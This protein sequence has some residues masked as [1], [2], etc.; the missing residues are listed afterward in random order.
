MK[1]SPTMAAEKKHTT[2]PQ[3]RQTRLSNDG[4]HR[5][6]FF[7]LVAMGGF[8]ELPAFFRVR[9]KRVLLAKK[10]QTMRIEKRGHIYATPDRVFSLISDF[11]R[12][13][14]AMLPQNDKI[15][16]VEATADSCTFTIDKAGRFGMR[17]VEREPNNLLK[18]ESM[19]SP[20]RFTMWIQLKE[21][22]ET[23]TAFRV[24]FDADI[25]ALMSV[26]LKKP[27]TEFVDMLVAKMEMIR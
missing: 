25:N 19:D 14:S 7:Q 24:T 22:H 13:N 15:K 23:E 6:V 1:K 16:D 20:L 2:Q 5:K 26:M 18:I 8:S 21:F 9:Q 27:L 17:I 10:T 4:K 12:I 3:G 11:S